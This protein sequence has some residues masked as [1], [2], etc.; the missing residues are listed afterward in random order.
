MQHPSRLAISSTRFPL[1]LLGPLRTFLTELV[2]I[3]FLRPS[4][5]N[6]RITAKTVS[7]EEQPAGAVT[8]LRGKAIR[9]DTLLRSK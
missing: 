7:P 9:F 6:T 4:L 5:V 2:T 1:L 3:D 8:D